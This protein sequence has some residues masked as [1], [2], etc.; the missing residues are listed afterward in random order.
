MVASKASLGSGLVFWFGFS[1]FFWIWIRV[2]QDFEC[3]GFFWIWI[4]FFSQFVGFKRFLQ[5]LDWLVFQA[6]IVGF[7]RIWICGFLRISGSVGFPGYRGIDIRYQSTSDTNIELAGCLCKRK[8][9]LYGYENYEGHFPESFFSS[10][11]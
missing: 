3:F 8:S 5:G 11:K 2:F 7:F 4:R 10:Y 1:G 6:W 9:T